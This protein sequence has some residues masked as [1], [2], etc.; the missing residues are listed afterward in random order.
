M[1]RYNAKST[2]SELPKGLEIFKDIL[3]QG[4]AWAKGSVDIGA[5]MTEIYFKLQALVGDFLPAITVQMIVLGVVYYFRDRIGKYLDH[6][7]K[8][9]FDVRITELKDKLDANAKNIEAMRSDVF[10]ARAHRS[11]TIESRKLLALEKVWSGIIALQQQ[12]GAVTTMALLDFVKTANKTK[13]DTTAKKFFSEG[14]FLKNKELY[15]EEVQFERPYLSVQIWSLYEVYKS[16]VIYS[17]L[18]IDVIQSGVGPELLKEPDEIIEA[19]ASAV[20]NMADTVRTRKTR[21]FP[22]ALKSIENEILKAI[23]GTLNGDEADQ[24]AAI[25]AAKVIDLIQCATLKIKEGQ[26]QGAIQNATN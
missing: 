18:Q 9:G 6:R 25:Q 23:K 21:V 19:I 17:S 7:V 5:M 24:A 14:V 1:C 12:S 26:I 20:P 16:I 4:V 13:N 8:H 3:Y 2:S 11:T 15:Q 10:R 22:Q